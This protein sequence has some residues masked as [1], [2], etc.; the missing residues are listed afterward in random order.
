M[1]VHENRVGENQ[2]GENRG[3][4]RMRLGL[5]LPLAI[6][7]ALIALF[8]HGLLRPADTSVASAFVGN[9]LPQFD[10]P[11]AN[12]ER[13]GLATAAFHSGKPRLL[14]IFASWCVPCAAESPQLAQL[15]QSGAVIEGIAIQDKPQDLAR[16]LANNGNPYAAIGKDD[17]RKVQLEIGSSGVPETF[18]I[19]GRG[20]IRYQHIGDIRPEDVPMLLAKL[21]EAG[22]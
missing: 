18:I 5:W 4:A 20:V 3:G 11:A 19:D 17:D 1:S 21:K 12:S 9:P 13:P 10:L 22:A 6:F 7:A 14:N 2:A 16:F 8:V 15:A